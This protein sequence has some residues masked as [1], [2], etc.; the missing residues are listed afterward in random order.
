MGI[1]DVTRRSGGATG[2]SV[3]AQM[4]IQGR[5]LD[6]QEAQQNR[7]NAIKIYTA[8]KD[9][10]KD[11][12]LKTYN[13]IQ[14][15]QAAFVTQH[16]KNV[17]QEGGMSAAAFSAKN[18]EFEKQKR[19]AQAQAGKF[20]DSLEQSSQPGVQMGYF[21]KNDINVFRQTVG[22][23]YQGNTLAEQAQVD[24]LKEGAKVAAKEEA[25][26]SDQI[27]RL[28]RQRDSLKKTLK[29]APEDQKANINQKIQEI[30]NAIKT[31]GTKGTAAQVPS[32]TKQE[33]EMTQRF[34]GIAWP[35]D[36]PPLGDEE[37]TRFN[38]ILASTAKDFAR[39][40]RTDINTALNAVWPDVFEQAVSKGEVRSLDVPI[41][42]EIDILK[43]DVPTK[44][45]T[46][47]DKPAGKA[48]GIAEG[49]IIKNDAT[50][51]RRIMKDGKWQ[52]MKPAL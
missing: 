39:K 44:L 8:Q 38:D 30:D 7:E 51:E 19:I 50:D 17:S 41:L 47:Q 6:I 12:A 18:A 10:I 21:D 35:K 24:A 49:T 29:T 32:P 34:I 42:G 5:K 36:L 43:S 33:Q 1:A 37:Q 9:K 45:K 31:A 11:N 28:Q 22:S 14:N 15:Q 46:S 26:P 25:K 40:N 3:G 48:K 2:F 23:I 52:E 27:T 4:G 20:I 16:Q 13:A